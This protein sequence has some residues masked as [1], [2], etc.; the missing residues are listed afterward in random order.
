MTIDIDG[1]DESV[2]L[3]LTVF[4]SYM[5]SP[6]TG[7]NGFLGLAYSNYNDKMNFVTQFSEA[8]TGIQISNYQWYYEQTDSNDPNSLY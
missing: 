7:L 2:V 4:V 6:E 3:D 5:A 8:T 1:Y